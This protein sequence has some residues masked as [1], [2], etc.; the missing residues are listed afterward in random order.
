MERKDDAKP[1][2]TRDFVRRE[3]WRIGPILHSFPPARINQISS[4]KGVGEAPMT[5]MTQK[6]VVAAADVP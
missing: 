2:R 1:K 4:C 6:A 5:P 3:D